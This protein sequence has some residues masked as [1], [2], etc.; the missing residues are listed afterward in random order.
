VHE[1][2]NAAGEQFG[3]A[4]LESAAVTATVG[5]LASVHIK[6]ALDAFRGRQP[7][8]DDATLVEAVLVPELFAAYQAPVL[9]W[10]RPAAPA[11][12]SGQ[13]RMALD[14]HAD[15][16]RVSDPV[17]MIL[18]QLREIPGLEE[19]RSVLDTVL[20]EL[21]SNA[22]EHG[23]LGLSS[24]LKDEP[25]GFERY[26]AARERELGALRDGWVRISTVCAQWPGGGQLVI[27]IEDS[28][29]GF[30]WRAQPP[31]RLHDPHGRGLHLVRGLCRTVSFEGEGNQVCATY[32]WG[33]GRGEDKPA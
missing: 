32:A 19:H 16:L 1:A 24:A 31:D 11:S 17:P 14:L 23:V 22:L 30:D 9:G 3:R 8:A 33:T 7:I 26:L 13:W 25:E 18:S 2:A 29:A 5:G 21:Y 27:R 15:A 20:S 28:G 12:A 4:R 6:A 10:S